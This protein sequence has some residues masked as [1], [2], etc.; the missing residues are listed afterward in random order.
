MGLKNIFKWTGVVGEELFRKCCDSCSN[1]VV[2]SPSLRLPLAV[3]YLTTENAKRM[4]LGWASGEF[5]MEK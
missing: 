1:H 4:M 3:V 5:A 2:Q